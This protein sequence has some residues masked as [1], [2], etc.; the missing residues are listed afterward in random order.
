VNTT[1]KGD[2]FENKAYEAI[3]LEL[4]EK[5]LGIMPECAK[6]F[7]KKAYYSRDRDA[8]II[9]DLSIEVTLPGADTYSFLWLWECKDYGKSVPVDDLE[10]FYAK[11]QQIAGVNVKGTLITNGTLQKSALNYAKAKGIGV[12]RL[13]PHNQIT[14]LILWQSDVKPEQLLASTKKH[15]S[16][17]AVAA[18][19][20]PKFHSVN[21][22]FYGSINDKAYNT[23]N[24]FIKET[25]MN[26]C[27]LKEEEMK[28]SYGVS[29][30]L[31]LEES[32]LEAAE[33]QGKSQNKINLTGILETLRSSKAIILVLCLLFLFIA[34]VVIYFRYK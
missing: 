33:M 10:E 12:A 27:G 7:T 24:L 34:L 2:A 6:L 4:S 20:I 11:I 14:W 21:G 28:V 1:K 17:L 19:T 8:N 9:V 5:R 26:E 29:A 15:L 18:L 13:L 31:E 32:L 16:A 23:L 30:P 25:I 3:K 22:E